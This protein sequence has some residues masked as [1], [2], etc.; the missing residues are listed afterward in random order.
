MLKVLDFPDN[1]EEAFREILEK[2][3]PQT[4]KELAKKSKAEILTFLI[5][6]KNNQFKNEVTKTT[7]TTNKETQEQNNEK[8]LQNAEHKENDKR[9]NKIKNILPE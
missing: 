1:K 2:Q 4:L 6:E 9:Y 3:D 8:E 5:Q 7:N